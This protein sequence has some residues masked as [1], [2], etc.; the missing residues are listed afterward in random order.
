F[1]ENGSYLKHSEDNPPP[2]R[3]YEVALHATPEQFLDWDK[4]LSGQSESVRAAF[5]GA[6]GHMMG[7][8]ALHHLSQQPGMPKFTMATDPE[9]AGA[10]GEAGIPGIRYLDER[11][12]PTRDISSLQGS[13]AQYE[14]I[15]KR[16]PD[17]Q[18]I[19]GL[20]ADAKAE[21]AKADA[22]TH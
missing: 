17:D 14:D 18:Y 12:R 16:R 3:M 13:V 7:R 4:P 6:P 9:V 5:P 1:D 2:G 8:D 22:G 11:S 21:L 20:L 10:L 19:S 15:L